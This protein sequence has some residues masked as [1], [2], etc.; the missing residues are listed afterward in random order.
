MLIPI[1]QV[2]GFKTPMVFK[3]RMVILKREYREDGGRMAKVRMPRIMLD[4]LSHCS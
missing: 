2:L 3:G 1:S 4:Y